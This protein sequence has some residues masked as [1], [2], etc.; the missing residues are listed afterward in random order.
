[1]SIANRMFSR[2][3]PLCELAERERLARLPD[4][5]AKSVLSKRDNH[6][7]LVKQVAPRLY[8]QKQHDLLNWRFKV[9]E[10]VKRQPTASI[11][12]PA[13]AGIQSFQ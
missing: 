8:I 9:D 7:G 4:G 3:T 5:A 1:M 6:F 12:I 10:I 13:T 2:E 11:V